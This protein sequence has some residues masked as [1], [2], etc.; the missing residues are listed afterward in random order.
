MTDVDDILSAEGE[1][2]SPQPAPPRRPSL[3]WSTLRGYWAVGLLLLCAALTGPIGY[4]GQ[5]GYAALVGVVGI[6]SLPTLGVK[7]SP[8]IEVGILLAL[9]LWCVAASTWSPAVPAHP[10]FHRYK[11]LE[12][13][14]A[15][16]LV[17]ELALYGAFV[18]LVREL[19]ER[20][21]GRVLATL[22]VS[23]TVIAVLMAI[24]ALSGQ[25]IYRALRLSAHAVGKEETIQSKAARGCYTVAVLFWPAA[26][27][28]RRVRWNLALIVLVVGFVV[29]ALGLNVAAPLFAVVIGGLVLMAVRRFGRPAI[30]VM[31]VLTVLYFALAPTVVDIL[32][33]F[34]PPMHNATGIAKE[35]WGA[36][37]AIWRFVAGLI[38]QRPWLGWGMDASRVFDPIPLHPHNAALQIWLEL[39]VVGVLLATLF[40]AWL[41]AR[42]GAQADRNPSEASVG[43]AT[44]TAY[45][46]I[47]GLS[48][49]VWQEWWLALG[50]LALVFCWTFSLA[51]RDW[52]DTLRLESGLTE[53]VPLD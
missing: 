26:L 42:L 16:K 4:A 38:A 15:L 2:L 13:L 29:A 50:V 7:R 45:L 51:F 3:G 23:L 28:M 6:A 36:R 30:W 41:W 33:R 9:V 46:T 19:P 12:G 20:W 52:S 44:A 37:V 25:A 5:L 14:T 49:G 22:A 39:G 32:G 53:L 31:L 40:W 48:F 21:A 43:A 17:F 8:L 18:F 10:D 35:S 34:A 47:G 1:R 27:W 11:Q 24:D